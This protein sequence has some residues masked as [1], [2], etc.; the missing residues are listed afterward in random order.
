MQLDLGQRRRMTGALEILSG[1]AHNEAMRWVFVAL[2][3]VAF[4]C[5]GSGAGSG[6]TGDGGGVGGLGGSALG[7]SGGSDASLGGVGGT[8]NVCAPGQQVQCACGGSIVG[9]Q[10]CN[11]DGTGYDACVCPDGGSGGTGGTTDSGTDAAPDGTAG[12]GG[13]NIGGSGGSDAGGC[14]TATVTATQI[15]PYLYVMLDKSSSMLGFK[16]DGTKAALSNFVSAAASAGITI[17]FKV[18]PRSPDS[19]PVCDQAAYKNPDTP[20]GLLPGSATAFS[21]ALAA[22]NPDGLNTPTWPALGGAVLK[23]IELA[24]TNPGRSA[25]VLLMTDGIPQGPAATCAGIDPTS[26]AEIAKLAQSGAN[27]AP[28][29][30]THVLGIPGADT[31][32]C[33]AVASAGGTTTAL[34]IGSSNIAQELT[35]ALAT[36]RSKLACEFEV[37]SQV[38][39][40]QV[41]Q[42]KVNVELSVSSGKQTLKFTSDCTT[43]SGWFYAQGTP[44][45]IGLCPA[46]CAQFWNDASRKVNI[47]LGC[48]TLT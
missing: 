43:K 8:S 42:N 40:G 38:T 29:V 19:T 33:N 15:S 11:K 24:Q 5:G 47:I 13:V 36:V 25:A 12:T 2:G 16:W 30:P 32:F 7:G 44:P 10:V 9:Y 31:T 28:P 27:S 21:I 4:S 26:T 35:T 20:F 1:S 37:P 45:K 34:M 6:G 3:V 22:V 18:Y 41:A 23:G 46:E 14:A 48:S 39:S 17:A